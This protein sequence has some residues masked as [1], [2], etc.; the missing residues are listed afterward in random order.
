MSAKLNDNGSETHAILKKKLTAAEDIHLQSELLAAGNLPRHIAI[1]MDGNGRWAKRRGLPRVAG[2]NEGV[3]SVKEAVTAC[4]E[5]HV[6][7][8]T[9]YAFSQ[10]NWKRPS[11]EVSALMKL[12]MRTIHNEL[13]NLNTQNVR[14][15]TIGHIELLPEKTLKQVLEAVETTKHNTGLVLNLALSYSGRIEI[16][17]AVKRIVQDIK[18]HRLE[19]NQISEEAIAR[20]L[21]TAGLP[22]PDLMIRT[23]GELR[24]S[25][26]LLWQLAYTEIYVTDTLWP[27]FRKAHLYEAIRNYQNRERRFGL[28]SE[29]VADTRKVR[30]ARKSPAHAS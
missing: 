27:D 19:T 29:Q 11:W 20:R 12:L 23:S 15:K 26:F 5:L 9:L 28:V 1:I 10:E 3:K 22:D 16:V 17:D 8:L 13:E 7:A 25:N 4:G 24:V 30:A 14:V 21:Y 18:H 2:H 6:Q